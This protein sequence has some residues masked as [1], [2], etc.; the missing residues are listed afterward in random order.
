MNGLIHLAINASVGAYTWISYDLTN[1]VVEYTGNSNAFGTIEKFSD[2]WSF[3][4]A[5]S[6]KHM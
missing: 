5:W 3:W 4:G 2:G 6:F 1:G